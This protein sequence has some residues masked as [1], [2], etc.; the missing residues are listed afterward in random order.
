MDTEYRLDTSKITDTSINR[1]VE[2]F[3]NSKFAFGQG[4]KECK[5]LDIKAKKG[6]LP[7]D[8]MIKLSRC[9]FLG[10][11]INVIELSGDITSCKKLHKA[12]D[13]LTK[14][15][16]VKFIDLYVDQKY[17]SFHDPRVF[18][19]T[20]RKEFDTIFVPYVFTDFFLNKFHYHRDDSELESKSEGSRINLNM[21]RGVL[22]QCSNVKVE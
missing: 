9:L 1:L 10:L 13:T 2:L 19:D 4:I 15:H 6:F 8:D 3:N 11:R 21:V 16:L 14:Y 17:P 22:I 18:K 7:E 5:D 20:I 12:Y